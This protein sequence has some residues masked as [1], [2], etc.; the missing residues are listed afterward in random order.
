MNLDGPLPEI[1]GNKTDPKKY[2]KIQYCGGWGYRPRCDPVMEALNA[3]FPN[4]LQYILVGDP[5]LTG[6]FE[7]TLHDDAACSGEGEM[8]HSK[9][10]SKKFPDANMDTFVAF[11]EG[12]LE[13]DLIIQ[14][15][16]KSKKS[17]INQ[18]RKWK[19]YEKLEIILLNQFIID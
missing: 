9:Q 18:I 1:L 14:N 10:A 11:V 17:N 15:R 4:Q 6:N 3:K 2:M 13:W 5:G 16:L 8:I 12:E 7:V 19:W